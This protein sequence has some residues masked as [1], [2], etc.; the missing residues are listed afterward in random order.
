M[1]LAKPCRRS[2]QLVPQIRAQPPRTVSVR[3]VCPITPPKR[4]EA[5]CAT[6]PCAPIVP[7]RSIVTAGPI[8]VRTVI[9]VRTIIRAIER[10][11]DYCSSDRRPDPSTA[12]AVAPP[13][14]ADTPASKAAASKTA[15]ASKT[16]PATAKTSATATSLGELHQTSSPAIAGSRTKSSCGEVDRQLYSCVCSGHRQCHQRHRRQHSTQNP[17][18]CHVQS[19]MFHRA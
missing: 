8:I 13:S 15:S 10:T 2:R 9:I 17:K 14:I 12:A 18:G 3:L 1:A 5:I 6:A 19:P 11:S 7:S 4:P 16:T